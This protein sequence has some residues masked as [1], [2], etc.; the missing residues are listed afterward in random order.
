MTKRR[1]SA[2]LQDAAAACRFTVV[3]ST[4]TAGLVASR[5]IT[6]SLPAVGEGR[7]TQEIATALNVAISTVETYRERI[8]G[9]LGLES[10]PELVRY[11]VVWIMGQTGNT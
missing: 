1:P 5:T 3:V 10:G 4:E 9:K 11:V 2:A 8:K 6:D 7:K